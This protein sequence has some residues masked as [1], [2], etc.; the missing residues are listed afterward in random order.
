MNKSKY[1]K[2]KMAI[3]IFRSLILS[4][5]ELQEMHSI[6]DNMSNIV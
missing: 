3:A 1:N 2:G 6:G 4:E 5:V